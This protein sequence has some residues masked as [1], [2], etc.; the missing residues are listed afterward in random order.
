MD[1][2]LGAGD[3]DEVLSSAERRHEAVIG[4]AIV[5]F[6]IEWRHDDDQRFVRF[7]EGREG[8]LRSVLLLALLRAE[9]ELRELRGISMTLAGLHALI[10]ERDHADVGDWFRSLGAM[11]RRDAVAGLAATCARPRPGLFGRYEALDSKPI[12]RGGY[13]AVWRG[14]DPNLDREVAIKVYHCKANCVED[15]EWY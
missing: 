10:P 11:P 12:A 14:H 13:G 2:E 4:P 8:E 6:D 5:D 1:D 9:R 3:Q 7:L 15:V